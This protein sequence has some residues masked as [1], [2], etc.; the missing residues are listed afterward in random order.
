MKRRKPVDCDRLFRHCI[1]LANTKYIPLCDG[2]D[3]TMDDLRIDEAHVLI[4]DGIPIDILMVGLVGLTLKMFLDLNNKIDVKVDKLS[5][6][7]NKVNDKLYPKLIV[8]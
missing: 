5:E 4:V 7:L 2:I 3:G 1:D 8:Q 6:D